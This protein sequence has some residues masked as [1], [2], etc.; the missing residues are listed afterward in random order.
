MGMVSA[1]SILNAMRE[2]R[3]QECRRGGLDRPLLF[4]LA[5]LIFI[6]LSFSQNL[7]AFRWVKQIDNS[8]QDSFS[9]MGVDAQGNTY[10][11]GS[12]S[13]ANFQV[14]AAIQS[15]LAS[16][17]FY[18]IDGPGSAYTGLG[19]TSARSSPSTRKMRILFCVSSGT[20]SKART[21]ARLSPP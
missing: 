18:R 16:A 10:I 20:S 5:A 12:T 3:R 17:G 14:K 4:M 9:G 6:P 1:F 7:P 2:L 19:L 8:G 13:S 21:A 15:H 11:A